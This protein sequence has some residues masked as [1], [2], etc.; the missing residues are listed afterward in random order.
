MPY[1]CI[2]YFKQFGETTEV[3]VSSPLNNADSSLKNNSNDGING[4]SYQKS[5]CPYPPNS[6][7]G[8]NAL[9]NVF[10][11]SSY[12]NWTAFPSVS[13]QNDSFLASEV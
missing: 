11:F 8:Y 3:S 4:S 2:K 13:G 9:L 10:V 7:F 1:F 5:F 12:S 6:V